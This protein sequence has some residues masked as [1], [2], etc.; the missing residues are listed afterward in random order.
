MIVPKISRRLPN[1]PY[2]FRGT[3]QQSQELV[4]GGNLLH[5]ESRIANVI[6]DQSKSSCC[7]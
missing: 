4:S 7:Q 3:V 5:L 1:P 6:D 2:R